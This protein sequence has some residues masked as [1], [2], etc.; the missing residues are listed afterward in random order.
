MTWS[1]NECLMAMG[2]TNPVVVILQI[3]DKLKWQRE[4]DDRT[5]RTLNDFE[6]FVNKSFYHLG[7]LICSSQILLCACIDLDA[8]PSHLYCLHK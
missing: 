5:V 2:S 3:G 1:F 7:A 4:K 8:T 6:A